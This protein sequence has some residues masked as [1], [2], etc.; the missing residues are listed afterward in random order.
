MYI[1]KT[2]GTVG[3][4]K[5]I[6]KKHNNLYIQANGEDAVLYYEDDSNESMFNSKRS[7]KVQDSMGDLNDKLTTVIY[8]I[9]AYGI[10]RS[11]IIGHLTDFANK[12]RQMKGLSSFRIATRIDDGSY[13]V[14]L[15]F[16][17]LAAY[18]DFKHTTTYKNYLTT[19]VLKKFRNEEGMFQ[20]FV[21]STIYFS[22]YDNEENFKSE[23]EY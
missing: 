13:L 7:Y 1:H 11:T 12:A 15:T 8:H 10:G 3:Y 16:V 22:L 14:M 19:E 4:L 20:D 9:P 18:H 17:E 6:Y 21:R 23:D 5:E 2:T